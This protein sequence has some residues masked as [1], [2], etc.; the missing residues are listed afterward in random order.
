MRVCK[1]GLSF[2]LA[3]TNKSN[4]EISL[5]APTPPYIGSHR[6]IKLSRPARSWALSPNPKPG[7]P[8]PRFPVEFRGFPALHAPLLKERRTRGPVQSCVQ[9]IRGISLVFREM[10]DTAGLPPPGLLRSPQLR[11][12]RRVTGSS[13]NCGRIT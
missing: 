10:W 13:R 4:H 1:E 6:G 2:S 11:L 7:A 12:A 9:E 5:S 3:L 8:H